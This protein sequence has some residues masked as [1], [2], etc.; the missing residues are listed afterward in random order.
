MRL[1]GTALST[2]AGCSLTIYDLNERAPSLTPGKV[3][4]ATHDRAPEATHDRDPEATASGAREIRRAWEIS[5]HPACP[6]KLQRRR[7]RP[8]RAEGSL[9]PWKRLSPERRSSDWRIA[10]SF[11]SS[12]ATLP[13]ISNRH[14]Y[15]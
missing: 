4:E 5:R 14:E 15:D 2:R 8:S 12:M 6:P 10:D 9:R 7:E 11:L 13:R 1:G 3:P